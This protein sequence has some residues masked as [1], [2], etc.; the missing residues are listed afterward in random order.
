MDYLKIVSDFIPMHHGTTRVEYFYRQ[1]LA[2]VDG[3]TSKVDES[4]FRYPG[5]KPNTKETGILMICEA[6]EAAVRSIKDPDIMKIEAMIDK[7][8]KQRI[9]DGQLM[10][11]H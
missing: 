7:I 10:S 3:D 8:I 5:P 9:D 1:A 11:V 4:Q 2:E 6:I